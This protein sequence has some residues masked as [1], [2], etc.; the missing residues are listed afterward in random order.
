MVLDPLLDIKD[1]EQGKFVDDGSGNIAV[2][3]A[4]VLDIEYA[5]TTSSANV[6]LTSA[7]TQYSHT[8]PDNTKQFRFR[9]RTAFDVRFSWDT[10]KVAT[11]ID[12]Y[13][14]LLAGLEMAGDAV[15]FTSKTLY[16]ATEEAGTIVELEMFT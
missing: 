13:S 10:G 5:T 2:R 1:L 3:T 16:F 8:L 7:D 14:T 12:P 6:V 15:N 4:V 9:A 11:P